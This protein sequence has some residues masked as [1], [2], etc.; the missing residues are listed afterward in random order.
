VTHWLLTLSQHSTD[1]CANTWDESLEEHSGKWFESMGVLDQII[2]PTKVHL[3]VKS[4][5]WHD[6]DL[7]TSQSNNLGNYCN[8]ETSLMK[9]RIAQSIS[10]AFTAWTCMPL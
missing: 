9:L 5:S 8:I 10:S 4:A 2:I 1:Q 6:F 3:Y 7:Y